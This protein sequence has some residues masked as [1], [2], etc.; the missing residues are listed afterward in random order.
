[1]SKQNQ[2]FLQKVKGQRVYYL[3]D[4]INKKPKLIARFSDDGREINLTRVW[5]LPFNQSFSPNHGIYQLNFDNSSYYI[6]ILV[7]DDQAW[8]YDTNYIDDLFKV[9][10]KRIFLSPHP[11]KAI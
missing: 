1:L 3:D 8:L 6:G 9:N 4:I 5:A 2:E 7:K 10:G 11:I